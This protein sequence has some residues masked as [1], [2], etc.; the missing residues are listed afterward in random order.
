MNPG[1][2]VA[3]AA[4]AGS[5]VGA[6][7]SFVSTWMAQRHQSRRELLLKNLAQREALYSDLISESARLL[8][9]ASTHHLSDPSI[10]IPAYALLSRIRLS[11][12]PQILEEAEKLLKVILEAYARPN[13]TVEQLESKAASAVSGD[14][15]LKSFSEICRVELQA[16]LGQV[17]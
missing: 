13:L 6:L 1:T 16:M 7:G 5:M 10:L 2:L 17:K 15:P 9:D 12:S 3:V 8:V 4:I 11:S 14:D